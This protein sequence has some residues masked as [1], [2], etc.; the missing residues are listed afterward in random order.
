MSK[1]LKK[2][3]AEGFLIVF[4]VLFALFINQQFDQYKTRERKNEA[5][6]SI[7]QE[8]YR[9]QAIVTSW[10]KKHRAILGRIGAVLEGRN[11]SL[12]QALRQKTYLD[13]GLLTNQEPIVNA[14]LTKTAWEAANST[15]IVSEFNFN[16]TQ[17]LTHVYSMQ[18]VM[19]DRTVVKIVDYYFDNSSHNLD[20]L[21]ET[22]IQFRLRFWELTGQETL[23]EHLYADAIDELNQL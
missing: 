2:Y 3:L 10:K 15:G 17:K 4:S 11:D 13:M 9:N 18:E 7:R 6:E 12:K 21:D 14:V 22:L 20:K 23:L 16:T 5:L 19:L 1:G 8:L